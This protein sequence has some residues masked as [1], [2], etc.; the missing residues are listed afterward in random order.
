MRRQ[1]HR[2]SPTS[3][4]LP[5]QTGTLLLP[6]AFSHTPSRRTASRRSTLTCVPCYSTRS[7]A[8]VS[9]LSAACPSSRPRRRGRRAAGQTGRGP[10]GSRAGSRSCRPMPRGSRRHSWRRRSLTTPCRSGPS[11]GPRTSA[12]GAAGRGSA[13]RVLVASPRASGSLTQ[14]ASWR[15]T[16]AS[17]SAQRSSLRGTMCCCCLTSTLVSTMRPTRSSSCMRS[18]T[19]AFTSPRKQFAQST[20]SG[21]QRGTATSPSGSWRW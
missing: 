21:T 17:T 16:V 6:T 18:R 19:E 13:W 12:M 1:T 20:C 2:S 15:S 4:T 5:S 11:P 8:L 7:R 10:T 14:T 9:W 3:L